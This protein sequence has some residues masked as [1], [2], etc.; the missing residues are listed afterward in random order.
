[1][2]KKNI[3]SYIKAS[4]CITMISLLTGCTGNFEDYNMNPFGPTPDDLLGDM[5]NSMREEHLILNITIDI[6]IRETV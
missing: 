2:R 6:C 1:M 4:V 5:R 3:K